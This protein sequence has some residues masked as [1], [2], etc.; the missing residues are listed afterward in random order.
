MEIFGGLLNL[1]RLFSRVILLLALPLYA[2]GAPKP[3]ADSCNFYLDMEKE[4]GCWLRED[5]ES[6]YFVQYG[7]KY[8]GLFKGRA[9]VWKDERTIWSKKTSL[10]LQ[11]AIR[12]PSGPIN[13]LKVESDAFSS[14]PGCYRSSG[15]C[16]LTKWQKTTVGRCPQFS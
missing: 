9:S 13:C 12:E 7:Y 5:H 15:F 11:N 2:F 4:F 8:C 14:H 16:D 1:K 6:N 3:S 10:C